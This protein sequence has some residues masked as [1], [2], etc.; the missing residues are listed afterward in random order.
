VLGVG[1]GWARQEFAAL[2]AE[3]GQRGTVTDDYLVAMRSAWSS[4]ADYRAGRIPVWVGGNSDAGLRRAVRLG[5]AWH[6]LRFTMAWLREAL[7]RLKA[8]A[9]ELQRPAP[10]LAPASHCGSRS[11]WSPTREGWQARAR[12]IRSPPTSS[13]CACSAQTRL[14]S[15]RCTHDT[16]TEHR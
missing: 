5:E 9:D 7:D 13:S 6:P 2:G 15:T 14:S 12:S 10:A 11:R 8:A 16:E 1:V 4:E 3:F